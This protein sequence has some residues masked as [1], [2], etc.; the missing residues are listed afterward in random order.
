MKLSSSSLKKLASLDPSF[1]PLANELVKVGQTAGLNVQIS[2]GLRTPAEQDALYAQGRTE[3]G[4]VV[5]NARRWTSLHNYGLAVDV[6]FMVD[7]K[8]SWDE[9]LFIL[10]WHK[11][12][13]AKLDQKGLVW[14]GKWKGG[15]K[16]MA[17]FQ[18]GRRSWRELARAH[19]VDPVTLNKIKP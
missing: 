5:T 1:L 18:L 6:F 12:I 13:E 7:G 2:S 15:L 10:L 11:A 16:E 3:K 8:A 4:K 14:S 9:A 17:H 19:G